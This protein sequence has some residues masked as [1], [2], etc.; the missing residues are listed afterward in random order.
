MP[1]HLVG[2]L[3]LAVLGQGIARGAFVEV[4]AGNRALQGTRVLAGDHLGLDAA[5]L[6]YRA[7]TH[8]HIGFLV[9]GAFGI[10]ALHVGLASEWRDLDLR[11]AAYRAGCFGGF[12]LA[13]GQRIGDIAVGP[14]RT[15]DEHGTGLLRRAQLQVLAALGAFA[16][17]GVCGDRIRERVLH[18]FGMGKQLRQLVGKQVAAVHD[19]LVLG[20]LALG[21]AVHLALQLR[22][23]IGRGHMG[24]EGSQR[25]ADRHAQRRRLDGFVLHVLH[26]VQALDDAMA[27]RLGAQAA[28]FHLLDEL[29]LGIPC[30][31]LGLLLRQACALEVDFSPL[32]QGGQLL[33]L[34]LAVRV[35]LAE[36]R[37]HQ[38]VAAR[39]EELAVHVQAH[40]G[41]LDGGGTGKG[42]QETARDQVIELV[43]GG[44]QGIGGRRIGGMDGRMVGGLLLAAGRM[45]GTARKQLLAVGGVRRV[46]RQLFHSSRQIQGRGI[47]RV[48]DARIADIAVHVQAF[49]D[50]HGACRGN[51]LGGSRR[52]QGGGIE[53]CRGLLGARALFDACD[54]GAAL[55]LDVL[56]DSLGACLVF[57]ARGR[58]GCAELHFGI[59]EIA[60]D[61]PIVFGD[62]CQALALALHDE[63][64][65]GGLHPAGAAHI[66]VTGELHQGE[67]AGQGGTPDQVDIL[68]GTS[69]ARQIHVHIHQI[70]EG[71]VDF[72]L[73][74]RGIA[75][76]G[77]GC[78]L[79]RLADARKRIGAD[80][81]ALA[82]EV[83]RNHDAVRLLRQVLERADDVLFLG[84]LLDG[85]IDQIRQRIHLPRRKLDTVFGE[86]LL[87]LEGGLGQAA[88]DV[89]RDHFAIR[90]DGSPAAALAIHQMGGE[91]RFEDMAAQADGD[92]LLS[93]A[94]ETVDRRGI[95]LVRFRLARSQKLCDLLGGDILLGYNKLHAK[96][97]LA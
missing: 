82:V 75:R 29:A 54:Q 66:A 28:L 89:C 19:H 55:A 49:G 5:L 41:A 81:L 65:R 24:R 70:L 53:R 4:L 13:L 95:H 27:R 51:A 30:R 74:D 25:I 43:C 20:D 18:L 38:H 58:M 50:A 93:I 96:T 73:G 9:G 42:C 76:T 97:S 6:A 59:I 71:M 3:Q 37:L 86:G 15:A 79:V 39:N 45:Q 46:A 32:D 78:G 2:G 63:R 1:A 16:H 11:H 69:R 10:D 94:L 17:I 52:H 22:G 87:F 48:V 62:E 44:V 83:G 57:E 56:H 26:G 33:V 14:A 60:L 23:H 80:Q 47:D 35:D 90:I 21:D 88:R 72:L 40:L 7:H 84:K 12:H 61:H 68:P 77:N 67:V 36:A 34:L 91:V 92:P 85:R 31:R 64:E 8:H